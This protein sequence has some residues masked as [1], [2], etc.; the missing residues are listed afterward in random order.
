MMIKKQIMIKTLMTLLSLVL[1]TGV[2]AGEGKKEKKQSKEQERGEDCSRECT[3]KGKKR[4]STPREEGR[5]R[6]KEKARL[7]NQEGGYESR[8]D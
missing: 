3:E 6:C 4:S 8:T 7:G 1:V 5:G 2:M